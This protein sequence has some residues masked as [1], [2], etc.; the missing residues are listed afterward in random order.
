MVETSPRH[1]SASN[2]LA[3]R[4]SRTIGEQLRTLR[5][6]TQNRYKTRI[7]PLTTD[8]RC[9]GFFVTR[10]AWSDTT[11]F[12][13][14]YDRDYTQEIVPFAE[15]VLFKLLAEHRGLSSGKQETLR[16][17]K[18]S[19]ANPVHIVATKTGATGA[20]TIRT[21]EPT[22][23]SET[24]LLLEIQAV[25]L[26]REPNASPRGRRKKHLTCAPPLHPVH[27]TPTDDE[28]GS[29]SDSSSSSS[30]TQA[31]S[32]IPQHA[33]V[34]PQAQT[35]SRSLQQTDVGESSATKRAAA[36]TTLDV[37]PQAKHPRAE[38]SQMDVRSVTVAG[39]AISGTEDDDLAEYFD[40]HEDAVDNAETEE[41]TKAKLKEL[42]RIAEF[43][44]HVALGNKRVRTRWDLDHREDGI[45][46]RFVAREFKDDET[47]HDVFAPS[48]TPS[49][50][51]VIDFLV[52][53]SRMIHVHSRRD[54]RVLPRG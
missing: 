47:M 11:P 35:I 46:A 2:G 9:V 25:P 20:R 4:S 31:P 7:T 21:L 48:S 14:A 29:T 54:Q 13:A 50:G 37:P 19:E 33:S 15:T 26:D 53:R 22:K 3:E 43:G 40:G 10:Y 39:V 52:S 51:R 5:Y 44:V 1:S 17:T 24:S 36:L 38:G 18:G 6:D 12:R 42:D 27:E 32:G 34:R 45:R 16:G 30:S 41:A 49:T 23:R 28:S 8:V